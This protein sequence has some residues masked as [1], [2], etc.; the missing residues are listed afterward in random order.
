MSKRRF[1]APYI[2][3]SGL[4]PGGE[5]EVIG[6]GSAQGGQTPEMLSFEEWLASDWK[7]DL[8]MDGE[9]DAYDYGAWWESSG[10]TREQ[11]EVI[12]PDLDWEEYVGG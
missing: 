10:F 11:W 3:L 9:I 7:Q 8:I 2:V 4:T 1:I 6:G 5:G 12:N